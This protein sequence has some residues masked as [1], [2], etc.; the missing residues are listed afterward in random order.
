MSGNRQWIC[1]RNNNKNLLI[2]TRCVF[3]REG[4]RA[5]CSHY[6]RWQVHLAPDS[7]ADIKRLLLQY[8]MDLVIVDTGFSSADMAALLAL[9]RMIMGRSALLTDQDAPVLHD[10][11]RAAG[12][13]MVRGKN[14]RL[15]AL[16]SELY[17]LMNSPYRGDDNKDDRHY[18]PQERD[19]L[20]GLLR[21]KRPLTIAAE[22]G[23]SYRDVS[24]Y[25]LSGLRRIGA[26]NMQ[27][28]IFSS[29]EK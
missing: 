26:R 29:T 5:L 11:Y 8:P 16:D 27:D 2:L 21:G 20:C 28:I 25:K 23:I 19:V 13:D 15:A 24:R 17:A 18:L 14:S 1:K 10:A 4:L 6:P 12:F 22:M 9:P 7:A 3:T